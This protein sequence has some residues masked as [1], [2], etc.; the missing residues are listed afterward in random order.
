[1][2]K[3]EKFDKKELAEK[4]KNNIDL[5]YIKNIL[6]NL[7]FD[8][9]NIYKFAIIANSIIIISNKTSICESKIRNNQNL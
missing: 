8:I 4:K 3:V 7:Q 2:R 5:Y 9:G 1:M 6:L